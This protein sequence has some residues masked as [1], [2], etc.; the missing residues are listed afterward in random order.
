[1]VSS[2][3]WY[4]VKQSHIQNPGVSKTLAHLEPETYLESST[5]QNP[6]IFRT[7][8]ILKTYSNIYEECF[9]KQITAII[10]FASY[11]YFRSISFS[12]PLVHEIK[13]IF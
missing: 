1:M 12:C 7:G 10:I 5:I 8:G 9:E 2:E 3:S 13:I 4:I 6:G 11:V